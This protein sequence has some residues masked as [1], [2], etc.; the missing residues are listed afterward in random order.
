MTE[1]VVYLRCDWC[2][3]TFEG[4]EAEARA[5]EWFQLDHDSFDEPKDYCSTDCLLASL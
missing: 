2:E 4:T 3:S 1:R 5:Q